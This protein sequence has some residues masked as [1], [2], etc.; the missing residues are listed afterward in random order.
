[1]AKGRN[2]AR[3]ALFLY[4]AS[5]LATYGAATYAGLPFDEL[6]ATDRT[7]ITLF[8][9]IAVGLAVCDGVRA[10]TGWTGC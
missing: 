4:A 6:K 5:Q 1:M 3:T 2:V 8:S 9:V 10:S 7:I